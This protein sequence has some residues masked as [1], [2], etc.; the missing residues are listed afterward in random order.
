MQHPRGC[1]IRAVQTLVY[2]KLACRSHTRA[3]SHAA[4]SQALMLQDDM[5]ILVSHAV[6]QVHSHAK[7]SQSHARSSTLAERAACAGAS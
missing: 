1:S 6:A 2:C 3:H 4:R 7:R 5:R